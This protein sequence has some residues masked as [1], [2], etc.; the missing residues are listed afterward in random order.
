[1]RR[2]T[3]E[4]GESIWWVR[5]HT[6]VEA[7]DDLDCASKLSSAPPLMEVDLDYDGCPT[8]EQLMDID[9]EQVRAT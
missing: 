9:A 3:G 6:Y 1:M 7:R 4:H 8:P 2:S 5:K